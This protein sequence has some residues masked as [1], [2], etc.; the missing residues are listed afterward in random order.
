M[1]RLR[2]GER[3]PTDTGEARERLID[4]AE[5]C[6]DR[7]GPAK[8]TLEDV[9]AEANVSRATIYR[10]FANRDELLLGVVLRE[11][12]RSND[13]SLDDFLASATGP[14]A[15]ADVLVESAAYLLS[16]IRANPK[17][18]IFLNRDGAAAVSGASAAF[19]RAFADDVRPYL[20]PAQQRGVL[21]QDIDLDE[22][23]EWILRC[24]L[25]LLV[26]EGPAART[27]DDERRLLRNFLVPAL[28]PSATAVSR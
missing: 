8:T 9:A 19:F 3:A 22:A 17:L 24:I 2:W 26:V 11:L 18:Q 12:D 16:S 15:A 13:G 4:A 1:S 20:E 6:L 25:S 5:A 14:D 27:P 23:A 28:V 7:F 21:R 10:Y